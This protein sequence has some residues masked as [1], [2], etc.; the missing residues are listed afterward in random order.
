MWFP[1]GSKIHL[2]GL[3][4]GWGSKKGKLIL[5]LMWG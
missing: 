3:I 2:S 1:K 5:G 4:Q